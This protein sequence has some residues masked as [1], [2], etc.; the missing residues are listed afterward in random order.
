MEAKSRGFIA[1]LAD[2][3]VTASGNIDSQ[4]YGGVS[5]EAR[6]AALKESVN[7]RNV[8]STKLW[9]KCCHP[10]FQLAKGFALDI[11]DPLKRAR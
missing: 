7:C 1:K 8:F 10:M 3:G 11:P 6:A 2:L 5:Q 4:E 9:I